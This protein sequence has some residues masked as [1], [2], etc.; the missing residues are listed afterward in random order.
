MESVTD[1][2]FFAIGY[3]LEIDDAKLGM[4]AR[5]H[6][7]HCNQ[8]VR[9]IFQAR[10]KSHGHITCESVASAF[11]KCGKPHFAEVIK[12]KCDGLQTKI[13]ESDKYEENG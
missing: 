1:I 2:N 4:I 5:R 6:K 10:V 11:E 9:E 7:S 12:Q 13:S 3:Q 8:V